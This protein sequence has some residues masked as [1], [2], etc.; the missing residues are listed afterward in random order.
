MKADIHPKYEKATIECACGNKIETRSTVFPSMKVE[1]CSACHPFYT[2]KQ[3]FIDT[4]GRVDKFKARIE[5]AKK[6]TRPNDRQVGQA[7]NRKQLTEKPEEQPTN[8]DKLT[9]IKKELTTEQK[10]AE[11]PNSAWRSLPDSGGLD[12][13]LEV[14]QEE[15]SDVELAA[16]EELLD[17]IPSTQLRTGKAENTEHKKDNQ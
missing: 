12:K 15:T 13:P 14:T 7:V 8:K 10:K 6:K 16:E 5:A 11:A 4:A 17:S 3:K 9:E 2:G 1:L